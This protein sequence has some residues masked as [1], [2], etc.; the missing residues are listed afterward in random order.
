[1]THTQHSASLP[2]SPLQDAKTHFSLIACSSPAAV[3]APGDTKSPAASSDIQL[4][5]AAPPQTPNTFFFRRSPFTA[6]SFGYGGLTAE[7]N[8]KIR[9][10]YSDNFFVELLG[11]S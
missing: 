11:K 3:A 8:N 9:S 4:L 6:V 7:L 5:P 10:G 2:F 1:H